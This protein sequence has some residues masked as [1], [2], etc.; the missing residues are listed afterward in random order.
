MKPV[1]KQY[2]KLIKFNAGDDYRILW[3]AIKT[4]GE[5]RVILDCD[6]KILKDVIK[7]STQYDA[8]NQFNVR[9]KTLCY[10]IFMYLISVF[11][12]IK[13]EHS[14]SFST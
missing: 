7:S 14:Y 4:L 2:T 1:G 11:L 8:M 9:C 3:K 13:L 10:V 12:L 6:P 5:R